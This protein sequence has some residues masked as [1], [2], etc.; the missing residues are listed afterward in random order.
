MSNSI[1]DFLLVLK[2]MTLF[3]LD[4]S[5]FQDFKKSV[6]SLVYEIIWNL[7]MII[8]CFKMVLP[9]VEVNNPFGIMLPFTRKAKLK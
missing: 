6:N 9:E 2:Y 1:F 4:F 5:S 7:F 8:S 3:F